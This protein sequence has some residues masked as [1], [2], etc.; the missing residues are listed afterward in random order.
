M[1]ERK[2]LRLFK[3]WLRT[4]QQQKVFK[5]IR[6]DADIWQPSAKAKS[7]KVY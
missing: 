3:Q 2:G 7:V 5:K 4:M 1:K 6:A